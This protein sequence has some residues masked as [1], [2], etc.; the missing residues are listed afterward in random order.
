MA[1]TVSGGEKVAAMVTVMSEAGVTLERTLD[2]VF[3]GCLLWLL[4]FLK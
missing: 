1:E 4:I 3:L 2:L